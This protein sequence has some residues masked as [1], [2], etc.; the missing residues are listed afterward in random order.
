[1]ANGYLGKI[2]FGCPRVGMPAT[3]QK[4]KET[5]ERIYYQDNLL[6]DSHRRAGVFRRVNF[7]RDRHSLAVRFSL[8][9]NSHAFGRCPSRVPVFLATCHFRRKTAAVGQFIFTFFSPVFVG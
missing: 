4:R 8:L 2:A 1:M 7:L 6:R 9:K 3:Y 5:N